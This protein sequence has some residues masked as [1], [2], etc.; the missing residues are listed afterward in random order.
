M[1]I[2]DKLNEMAVESP[3][4]RDIYLVEKLMELSDIIAAQLRYL[5]QRIDILEMSSA[6]QLQRHED[7]ATR[8]MGLSQRVSTVERLLAG[9]KS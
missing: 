5:E 7:L 1:S 9:P 8:N 3:L 4:S 6:R 2:K